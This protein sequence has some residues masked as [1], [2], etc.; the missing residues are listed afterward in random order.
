MTIPQYMSF[1]FAIFF[2]ISVSAH[3][4]IDSALPDHQPPV[5]E[6]ATC[7]KNVVA[8]SLFSLYLTIT[9]KSGVQPGNYSY[10]N[11][12][13]TTGNSYLA[14]SSTDLTLVNGTITDGTWV[15]SCIIPLE[16]PNTS[17]DIEVHI[18][19]TAGNQAEFNMHHAFDLTGGS[20]ND[21]KPPTIVTL[22]LSTT[23]VEIGATL[24]VTVHVKDSES[25]LRS[26]TFQAYDSYLT[27]VIIC[28][29]SFTLVSGDNFDG[30]WS[31]SCQIP[32]GTDCDYYEAAAYA[33]DVQNNQSMKTQGFK[34]I[35]ASS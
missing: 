20:P 26:L 18:L 19:D 35:P 33:T 24:Q 7:P 1:I 8:G 23:A 30:V 11:V 25:G 16:S 6:S 28:K 2:I 12:R 3:E 9:D 14:C 4:I 17:Y 32:A 34:V 27:Y 15:L 29:G 22:E 21:L 10:M 5:I 13:A 31:Y